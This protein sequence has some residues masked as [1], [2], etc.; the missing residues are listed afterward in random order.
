V[1]K[2]EEGARRDMNRSL[3]FFDWNLGS[4]SSLNTL[5]VRSFV[6][7]LRRAGNISISPSYKRSS[8][9]VIVGG[10]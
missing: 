5:L 6:C 1:V 3:L 4:R 2:E 7:C 8:G 10:K 9:R